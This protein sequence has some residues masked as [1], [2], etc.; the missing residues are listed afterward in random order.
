MKRKRNILV[1]KRRITF[2][3]SLSDH[4]SGA[5]ASGESFNSRS[6]RKCKRDE[7]WSRPEIFSNASV[8][9]GDGVGVKTARNKRL[10][11][12]PTY[13]SAFSNSFGIYSTR[14]RHT[15]AAA[16]I[17]TGKQMLCP[18]KA[19]CV[20]KAQASVT[21]H[22]TCR[23]ETWFNYQMLCDDYLIHQLVRCNGHASLSKKYCWFFHL[24]IINWRRS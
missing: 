8:N 1:Y 2:S 19:N 20:T 6:L 22:T 4:C 11:F 23:G 3:N 12:R 21:R 24:N 14:M 17:V 13:V 9:G 5:S 16:R 7:H 10:N 18:L 15:T